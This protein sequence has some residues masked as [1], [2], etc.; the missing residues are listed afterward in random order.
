MDS[1]LNWIPHITYVN[2]S[3]GI[4]I[5]FKA[6]YYLNTEMF[7]KHVPHLYIF[8]SHL[9]VFE[10]WGNASHCHLRPLFLTQKKLFS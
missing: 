9:I 7:V 10:M 6:R 3:K 5:M 4:R 8:I 2:I 1:K